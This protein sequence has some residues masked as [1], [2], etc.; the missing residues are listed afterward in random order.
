MSVQSVFDKYASQYDESR[1]KLIPCFDDFYQTAIEIIPFN[2][3]QEIQVLDLGSGTG[4]MASLV[5]S[6][7]PKAEITLF[8]VAGKML[9]EA[10]KRLSCHSNTFSF[11]VTDYAQPNAFDHDYDLIISSLSIHH[12]TAQEKEILFKSI[13][14]HLKTGGIF[15]NADQV[16]GE[17]DEIE[18]R[19]RETWVRQVKARGVTDEELQAAFERMEEDKMSTL[20]S[21]MQ[22]LKNIDFT[23]VNCW[24]QNYSFAVYSGTKA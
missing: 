7:F 23:D 20:T 4:L 13:Y 17:T 21:Q 19:Y 24:Y 15:I 11:K 14:D 12:L 3:D 6:T 18:K 8:D 22:W 5:A 10:R 2:P 9:E 16:L 1:K